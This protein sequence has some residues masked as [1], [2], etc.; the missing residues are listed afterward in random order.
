MTQAK[1]R[2]EFRREGRRERAV[3]GAR[4]FKTG[5]GQYGA[6]DRFLGIT[7]PVVRRYARAHRESDERTI[8]ALL[9][10]DWH[11]ERLLGLLI[12]VEQFER[13]DEAVRRHIF[14]SYL[15]HRDRVNNW[16][17]VDTSAY[18]IVGAYLESRPMDILFELAGSERMWDRRL[19]IVASFHLIKNGD[20][21]V[22]LQLAK[23]LL[24]DPEDLMH[25]ATG[26][27][28]REVGKHCGR[29]ILERFLERHAAKMP[30]TMLR[31][32]LEHFDAADR[33]HFM[34]KKLH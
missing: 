21:R 25:K 8:L 22:A 23:L 13:G 33:E 1:W 11:E 32:A 20:A 26:W 17:L 5:P 3:A 9:A 27:M 15:A 7:V 6:G 4:Y 28:L 18:K 12:W 31:Y 2:E 29:P 34:V 16:D 24:D 30:R 10:S 14:E 19:A